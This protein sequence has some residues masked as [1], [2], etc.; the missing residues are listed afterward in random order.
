MTRCI[1]DYEKVADG[2]NP[3]SADLTAFCW[4]ELFNDKLG[5]G[6]E[7]EDVN[8][9]SVSDQVQQELDEHV[10]TGPMPLPLQDSRT[11]E[12]LKDLARYIILS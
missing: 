9:P 6:Y 10:P 8:K 3:M 1:L 11:I 2:W 4:Q 12:A 7:V 5:L